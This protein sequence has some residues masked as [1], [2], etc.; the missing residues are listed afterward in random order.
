MGLPFGGASGPRA[1]SMLK[2]ASP[3]EVLIAQPMLWA[4][5]AVRGR[6]AFTNIDNSLGCIPISDEIA[7]RLSRCRAI[8]DLKFS[9]VGAHMVSSRSPPNLPLF[10]Y[11]QG[12]YSEIIVNILTVL[13]VAGTGATSWWDS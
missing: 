11:R 3:V 6:P 8:S 9:A 2:I 4:A 5:H 13:L 12:S 7:S 1:I 10:G